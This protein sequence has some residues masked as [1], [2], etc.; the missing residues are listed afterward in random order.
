M[1]WTGGER[2]VDSESDESEEDEGGDGLRGGMC[3]A[4]SKSRLARDSVTAST[5][6]RRW[7]LRALD[8]M[9]FWDWGLGF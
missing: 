3:M 4:K 9:L 6:L 1:F 7:T 8:G 5:S 2:K